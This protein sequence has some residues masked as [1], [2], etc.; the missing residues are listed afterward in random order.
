MP[1]IYT[2]DQT[3][4]YWSTYTYGHKTLNIFNCWNEVCYKMHVPHPYTCINFKLRANMYVGFIIWLTNFKT[5]IEKNHLL[6]SKCGGTIKYMF[7]KKNKRTQIESHFEKCSPKTS[8][9]RRYILVLWLTLV[10][11]LHGAG[12][13]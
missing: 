11:A 13:W 4:T 3:Y 6:I 7:D 5:W 8:K 1:S 12:K 9:I 10:V 2:A